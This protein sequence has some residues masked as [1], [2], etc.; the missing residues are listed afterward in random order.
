MYCMLYVSHIFA[1]D[2]ND[3][4]CGRAVHMLYSKCRCL[5][6]M[7]SMAMNTF[8]I[9]MTLQGSYIKQALYFNFL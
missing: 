1:Y 5:V 4:D 7:V 6:S 2:V 9:V 3:Q 8:T